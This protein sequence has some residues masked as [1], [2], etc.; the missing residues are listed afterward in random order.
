MRRYSPVSVGRPEGT[1]PDW[2]LPGG[3]QGGGGEEAGGISVWRKCCL[4]PL[5]FHARW[6]VCAY[7]RLQHRGRKRH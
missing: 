5:V 7:T 3:G 2:P 6:P 4:A 1:L